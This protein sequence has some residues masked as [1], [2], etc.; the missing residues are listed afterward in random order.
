HVAEA[1]R[2]EQRGRRALAL[3]ERVDDDGRAVCEELDVLQCRVADRGHDA[4]LEPS[5]CRRAL[6]EADVAARLVEVDEVGEGPADVDRAAC[7]QGTVLTEKRPPCSAFTLR[8]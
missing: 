5:G 6:R 3:G 1:P 4:L 7:R 8:R 2:R